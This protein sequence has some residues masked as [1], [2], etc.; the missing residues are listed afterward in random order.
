MADLWVAGPTGTCGGLTGVC[1]LALPFADSPFRGGISVSLTSVGLD[2]C[3]V[4]VALFLLF[5]F[6][7]FPLVSG[8]LFLES[9]VVVAAGL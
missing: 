6:V 9:V 4:V 2:C 3:V 8:W 1:Y 5:R 7:L